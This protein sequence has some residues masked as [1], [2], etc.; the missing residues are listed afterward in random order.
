MLIQILE[1]ALEVRILLIF[2]FVRNDLFCYICKCPG[3]RKKD[4]G[5]NKTED[6]VDIGNAARIQGR[7]PEIVI[8]KSRQAAYNKC[9]NNEQSGK[10]VI[11]HVYRRHTD[12]FRLCAYPAYQ[13][14]RETVTDVDTDNNGEYPTEAYS[15]GARERLQ[16]TD[17]SGRAL[18][19]AG[20]NDTGEETEKIVV[21]EGDQQTAQRIAHLRNS[22]AHINQSHEQ[23]TEAD[24]YRTRILGTPG[25][26][27]HEADD[28]GDQRHRS[29]IVRLEKV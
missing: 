21:L 13:V 8:D 3:E 1:L 18:D 2:F 20:H 10:Y 5:R 16:N 25:L 9:R 4:N 24:E 27:E 22:A 11:D 29:K 15:H 12:L 28:T 23:D 7:I 17:N 6:T 14:S 26:Y 19:N